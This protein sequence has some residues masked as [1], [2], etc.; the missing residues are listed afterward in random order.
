MTEVEAYFTNDEILRQA[1]K[2]KR[3]NSHGIDGVSAKDAIAIAE[4]KYLS[5]RDEV[6]CGK[7]N[8]SPVLKILIPKGNGK[9]REIGS[10][11]TL[12]RIIQGCI[13]N[14][15]Y[16]MVDTE[17]SGSSFGF[18]ENCNC[19]MAVLRAVKIIK[20][21]Y[22]WVISIDIKDCFNNL[23]KYLILWLLRNVG[24]NDKIIRDINNIISNN[25][26]YKGNQEPMHGCPQGSNLS[27]D[28]CN[29]V[30]N[31]L[32]KRLEEREHPFIRYAD[33]IYVFCKSKEA[34]QRTLLST[35][36][37]L[38]KKLKLVVN[39]EKTCVFHSRQ[40]I[41]SCLGFLIKH[42]EDI[43]IYMNPKKEENLRINIKERMDTDSPNELVQDI[44]SL[45]CGWISCN[46]IANMGKATKR[47][48]FFIKRVLNVYERKHGIKIDRT[49]LK[50]CHDYYK[51]CLQQNQMKEKESDSV[52]NE[53]TKTNTT[54]PQHAGKCDTEV[55]V[56]A[57]APPI[58]D[59]IT[60]NYYQCYFN[61]YHQQ[62]Q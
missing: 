55:S 39:K 37:F 46:S 32:D 15:I 33:D 14:Y 31:L 25:Y 54:Q 29:L 28:L 8:P 35:V 9:F 30:L 48:D 19:Q 2:V 49:E 5:I 58:S 22:E 26:V 38:E 10:A 59:S 53:N 7:Y 34:A 56:R 17:M 41:W 6:L 51:R 3:K 20:A 23:D 13:H 44:N 1:K 4:N 40:K 52:G 36:A 47:M 21:G 16:H 50:N 42:D 57:R 60:K 18:R 12:D 24:V 62:N 45:A 11:N 27:P 61:H 43:H